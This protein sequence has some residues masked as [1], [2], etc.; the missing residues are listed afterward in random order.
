MYGNK[1]SIGRLSV[2]FGFLGSRYKSR[3]DKTRLLDNKNQF[4]QT[5][6]DYLISGQSYFSANVNVSNI[7]SKFNPSQDKDKYTGLVGL[8]WQSSVI[9]EL[10]FLLGYQQINFKEALFSDD[11]VA[12]WRVNVNWSPVVSTKIIFSTERNF[13]EANRLTNS[14]R[15]VDNYQVRLITDFAQA[16][17]ASVGLNYNNEEVVFQNTRENETYSVVDIQLKYQ[18]NKWLSLYLQYLYQDVSSE[19]PEIS[20]QRSGISLGFSVSI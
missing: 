4:I 11:S 20:Y 2:E 19:P 6:F 17:Q 13:E 1:Y 8:K 14:Y 18:R 9:T 10:E 3:R 15:V 5:S 12:K 7:R 16:I